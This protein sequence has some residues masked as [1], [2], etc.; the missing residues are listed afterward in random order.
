MLES[1][2]RAIEE[3]LAPD[4]RVIDVGGWA[5][6]FPRA[7]WVLD[8]MPY[9]T[10][11][12]YGELRPDEERFTSETWVQRDICERVPWPFDDDAFDFAV[13]SHTLEDVRDP[14]W[15]CSELSR[16]AKAGYIEVPSR[17]EEQCMGVDGQ[18][19]AG[20]SHHRW[21]ID[22]VSG[23]LRFVFKPHHLH[24]RGEAHF[25]ATFQDSLDAS[26]RVLC[27]WWTGAIPVREAVFIDE[28]DVNDYLDAVVAEHLPP[29]AAPELERART[30]GTVATGLTW[31]VR[32]A[33]RI[34]LRGR[35][36]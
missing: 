32:S 23:A 19:W 25:P 33:S 12:L 15:V 16:V 14:I 20:W 21:L 24:V 30:L 2:V 17:L 29:T 31:R 13:C 9:E 11:G 7:D 27:F 10:R 4:A 8:L 34:L 26:D 6:P 1:S 22:E 3:Q 18:W 5:S 36:S 28:A 35:L